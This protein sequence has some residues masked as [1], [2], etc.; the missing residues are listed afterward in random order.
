[1]TEPDDTQGAIR[2]CIVRSYGG[3]DTE[4]QYFR[5]EDP[6]RPN[7][8]FIQSDVVAEVRR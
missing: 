4:R 5:I 2:E 3:N 6:L 7:K 1:M 8:R